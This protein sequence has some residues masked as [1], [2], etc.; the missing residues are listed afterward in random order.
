[1]TNRSDSETRAEG[2]AVKLDYAQPPRRRPRWRTRFAFAIA[3]IGGPSAGLIIARAGF[4]ALP[5]WA[6]ATVVLPIVLCAIAASHRKAIAVAG[7]I[8]MMLTF[9]SVFFGALQDSLR[10]SRDEIGFVILGLLAMSVASILVAL[11]V[12]WLVGWLFKPRPT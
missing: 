3:L 11:F 4:G 8:F 9:V 12:G 7:A 6:M 5:V 2:F 1:V 10:P